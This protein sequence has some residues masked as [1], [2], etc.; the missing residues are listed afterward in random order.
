MDVPAILLA[1]RD[2]ARRRG[3]AVDEG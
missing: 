3:L 2:E 1:L